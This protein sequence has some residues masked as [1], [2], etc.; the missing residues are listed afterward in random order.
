[1][2]KKILIIALCFLIVTILV[3]NSVKIKLEYFAVNPKDYKN[4]VY[5][6]DTN[7]LLL[8][9]PPTIN[10]KPVNNRTGIVKAT[11]VK[12]DCNKDGDDCKYD[13]IF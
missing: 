6:K 1:M 2:S 4:F 7:L 5:Q 9:I 12:F 11:Q 13:L 10:N 3:V 8:N